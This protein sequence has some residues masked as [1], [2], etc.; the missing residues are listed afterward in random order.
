MERRRSG[1]VIAADAGEVMVATLAQPAQG[2]VDIHSRSSASTDVSDNLTPRSKRVVHTCGQR[3]GTRRANCGCH[4]AQRGRLLRFNLT[5]R[6]ARYRVQPV[7]IEEGRTAME[8]VTGASAPIEVR[9]SARRT[10]TVSA[11]RD[12]EKIVVLVPARLSRHQEARW[13]RT[14]VDDIVAREQRARD[15]GPRRSDAALIERARSLNQTY[16]D[17]RADP[18]SVRWVDTMQRRWASCTSIDRT[19]RVSRRL[20]SMPAWVVDYVLVHELAHIMVSGHGADF[21]TLVNRYQRTERARG[22][23]EGVSAAA[24]LDMFE[25]ALSDGGPDDDVNP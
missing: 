10:R 3:C 18:C 24:H 16:L 1:K 20:Q 9:R 17:G 15:A 19:I 4:Q 12:G 7:Q 8:G 5:V 2:S 11:Y 25:G 6:P 22:Y 23:L 13:V 21:W 14:M